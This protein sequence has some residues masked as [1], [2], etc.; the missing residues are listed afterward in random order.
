M[1]VLGRFKG[2]FGLFNAYWAVFGLF[3]P[4]TEELKKKIPTVNYLK[5]YYKNS[6]D[7]QL[8]MTKHCGINKIFLKAF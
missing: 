1:Y 8:D 6:K 5:K 4:K 3:L 7:A 2:S